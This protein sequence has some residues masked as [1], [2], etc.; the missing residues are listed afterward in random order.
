LYHFPVLSPWEQLP[1]LAE[2]TRKRY[3]STEGPNVQVG[4]T[5]YPKIKRGLSGFINT[6]RASAI[7]D[8]GSAQN[9]ISAA[10]ALDLM[11]PIEHTSS[12]FRVGNSKTV[13]S[14]GRVTAELN[15]EHGSLMVF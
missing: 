8:T 2:T 5:K 12:S 3:E 11:L 1:K 10:Y 15:S 13:Q 4:R 14:I 6:T 9:V 7:A